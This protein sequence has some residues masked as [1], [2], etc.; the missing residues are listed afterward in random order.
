[1]KRLA[2]VLA[3]VLLAAPASAQISPPNDAGVAMGHLHYHVRDVEAGSGWR[4]AAS[5][6]CSGR[7]P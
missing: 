1:M 7:R 5:A 4:S 3:T 2:C 6:A